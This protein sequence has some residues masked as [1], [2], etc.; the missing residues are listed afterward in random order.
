MRYINFKHAVLKP[1]L[2]VAT[3]TL[4]ALAQPASAESQFSIKG[5]EAGAVSLHSFQFPFHYESISAQGNASHIGRY[6]L[7]GDFAVD[8]RVGIS[9]GVFTLTTPDGDMLFLS[10]VGHAVADSNF[11]KT[12]SAYTI[13]GGS[14]QFEGAAGNITT[15][16]TFASAV[17]QDVSPNPYT[18][19]LTGT[20]ILPAED[21]QD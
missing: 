5:N 6:T 13:T 9:T 18:A 4:L 3:L 2:V 12:V 21:D 8:V 15:S 14:G 7:T 10:L 16:N 11:T 17:N 19:V 1:G 20:L